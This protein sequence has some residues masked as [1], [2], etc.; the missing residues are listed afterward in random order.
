MMR[1]YFFHGFAALALVCLMAGVFGYAKEVT[2][3]PIVWK[4]NIGGPKRAVAWPIIWWAEEMEK[5]T[6]GRFKVEIIF[7]SALGPVKEN[8]EAVKGGLFELGHTCVA[9]HPGKLPLHTVAELPFLPPVD[10]QQQFTWMWNVVEKQP[11]LIKFLADKWNCVAV[12][13]LFVPTYQ[14]FG[15]RPISTVSDL[16]GYRLRISGT[17]AKV[18]KKFGAVTMM[19]PGP[20]TYTALER[21]TIDGVSFPWTYGPV[22]Y[23]LHEIAKYATIGVGPGI[24]CPFVV[25]NKSKWDALP[26]EIRKIHSQ[27]SPMF[28]EGHAKVY[29]K[30]DIKNFA[31]LKEA[32]VEIITFPPAERAKL[33]AQARK[34]W[35]DWVN[36]TE[37]KGLPGKNVMQYA[38]DEYEKITG[39][40][41]APR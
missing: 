8:L 15:R 41:A 34:V 17:Q 6:D 20:E 5:R 11:D 16:A 25:A 38:M 37:K 3:E 32:K 18:M 13:P 24:S 30:V 14:F 29:E 27:L 31:L 28:A 22:S 4:V 1:R 9:Y 21:G 10:N 33:V 39:K 2:A 35:N 12:V 23:K 36:S 40:P 7:N 26:R 19:V